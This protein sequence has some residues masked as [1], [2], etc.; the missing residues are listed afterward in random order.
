ML[1]NATKYD[2]TYGGYNE[3]FIAQGEKSEGYG[4]HWFNLHSDRDTWSIP[5]QDAR[6]GYMSFLRGTADKAVISTGLRFIHI[7]KV[8]FDYLAGLW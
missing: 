4:I 2:V 1:I 7:P 8:D 5:L 3:D 6:Y